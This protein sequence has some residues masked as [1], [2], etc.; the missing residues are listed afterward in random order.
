VVRPDW[1]SAMTT[2]GDVTNTARLDAPIEPTT[3]GR[4]RRPAIGDDE[5]LGQV[6]LRPARPR[7]SR[8]HCLKGHV[9][10]L[11]MLKGR[12]GYSPYIRPSQAPD[13]AHNICSRIRPS[14]AGPDAHIDTSGSRLSGALSEGPG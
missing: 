3:A 14:R 10:R 2:D 13:P 7:P 5:V 11:L 4:D 1:F 9:N 8:D 6:P 12:H